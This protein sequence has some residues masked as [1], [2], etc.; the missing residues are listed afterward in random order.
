MVAVEG[1]LFDGQ[2]VLEFKHEGAVAF[3]HVEEGVAFVSVHAL[4]VQGGPVAV[5][6]ELG[7]PEEEQRMERG[8]FVVVE[9]FFDGEGDAFEEE[10]DTGDGVPSELDGA[11]VDEPFLFLGAE[12]AKEEVEI[13]RPE[14]FAFIAEAGEHPL[15]GDTDEVTDPGVFLP[16]AAGFLD[17][18]LSDFGDLA[19]SSFE[20][21]FLDR[22]QCIHGPLF[23]DLE[24]IAGEDGRAAGNVFGGERYE[25]ASGVEVERFEFRVL[26]GGLGRD[27]ERVLP[28][29]LGW[30]EWGHDIGQSAPAEV[31]GAE[32][33]SGEGVVVFP[34][35]FFLDELLAFFDEGGGDIEV[36]VGLEAAG[37]QPVH[38]DPDGAA[39]VAVPVES[40]TAVGGAGDA[41]VVVEFPSV[42][43][44]FDERFGHGG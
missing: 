19:E 4:S 29:G 44:V 1:P 7:I 36:F 34:V 8:G 14:D 22:G 20:L 13:G 18:V 21:V 9:G 43:E 16:F 25:F 31:G 26:S 33:L 40:F 37:E 17:E 39:P 11:E 5:D 35:A 30:F 42:H 15:A 27:D 24:N 10:G 2:F 3:C 12:D 32:T 41:E 6:G 28:E 38:V 23:H